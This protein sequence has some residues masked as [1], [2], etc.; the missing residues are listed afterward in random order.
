VTPIDFAVA[1]AIGLGAGV[2]AGLFGVGGGVLLVPA[3]VIL[4]G[5]DQHVAQGT[6]LLVIIPTA[7]AGTLANRRG[8][9]VDGRQAAKVAAGGIGGAVLGGIL[10]TTLDDRSLRLLFVVYLVVVGVRL[11]KPVRPRTASVPDGP[12]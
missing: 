2:L 10:A 4:L 5:F 6:S 7:I 12:R 8:G 9:L 11:L 1:A 3:L